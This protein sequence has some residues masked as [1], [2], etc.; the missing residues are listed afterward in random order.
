M[1]KTLLKERFKK[2]AGI[3][4]I[5]PL[6]EEDENPQ[7]GGEQQT[8]SV[9][10]EIRLLSDRSEKL[11]KALDNFESN[12]GLLID[13]YGN[14]YLNHLLS[15]YPKYDGYVPESFRDS[16]LSYPTIASEEMATILLQL[17]IVEEETVFRLP[18]GELIQVMKQTQ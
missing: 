3:K 13:L 11:T 9:K 6:S 14:S 7:A 15:K 10:N 18:S 2:L 4:S 8:D 1:A 5:S 12:P 17:G 16:R